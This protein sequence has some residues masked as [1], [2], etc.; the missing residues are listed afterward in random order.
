MPHP[1]ELAALRPGDGIQAIFRQLEGAQTYDAERMWVLIERMDDGWVY[2][3]LDNEPVGMDRFKLGDPV[4]VPLTHA[5]STAFSKDNPRPERPPVR[6][7]WDRCFVDDCVVE[8]RCHAD[9]LYREEPDMTREGDKYQDSGWRIRGT[10]EA[11]ADDKARSLDPVY[12][13]LG[14]VL[15]Q[16]DRWLHLIDREIGVA[17]QWDRE[18]QDYIELE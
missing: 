6:E 5:I 4:V 10:D 9:Y 2:G 12:I 8:G 15:N 11:I 18:A 1:D 16:D 14:K 7:Y 3:K 17:F 13:A